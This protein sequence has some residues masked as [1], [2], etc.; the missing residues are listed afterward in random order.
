[1]THGDPARGGAEPYRSSR[2]STERLK[3]NDATLHYFER[4]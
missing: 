3:L 1:M 2:D 4:Y